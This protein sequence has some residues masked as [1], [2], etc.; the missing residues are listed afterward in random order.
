M[1]NMTG[2]GAVMEREEEEKKEERGERQ[3]EGGG[4]EREWG[5]G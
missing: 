5:G 1:P 2:P 3:G 4:Q